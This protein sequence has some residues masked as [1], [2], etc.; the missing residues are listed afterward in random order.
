M[1]EEIV[2]HYGM[3]EDVAIESYKKDCRQFGLDLDDETEAAAPEPEFNHGIVCS[4]CD[5]SG[6]TAVR[7]DTERIFV[8]HL[9]MRHFESELNAQLPTG[10]PWECPFPNCKVEPK[11]NLHYL[12]LHYG[13]EHNVARKL[14]DQRLNPAAAAVSDPVGEINA[15]SSLFAGLVTNSTLLC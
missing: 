9:T 3:D 4:L 15:D 13:I 6:P 10:P 2:M 7:H 12:R 11:D 8:R 5:G 1:L 14:Y